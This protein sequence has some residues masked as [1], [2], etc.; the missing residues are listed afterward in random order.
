MLLLVTDTARRAACAMLDT[1]CN[2]LRISRIDMTRSLL[3]D[4]PPLEGMSGRPLAIPSSTI[5]I[6]LAE[7]ITETQ[8][9]SAT[10]LIAPRMATTPSVVPIPYPLP[11]MAAGSYMNTQSPPATLGTTGL[12]DLDLLALSPL[13]MAAAMSSMVSLATTLT[14]VVTTMTTIWLNITPTA[15]LLARRITIPAT[16]TAG[17]VP[18]VY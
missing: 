1:G 9:H 11:A 7:V 12:A 5:T 16:D 2:I 6:P 4:T 8:S 13:T 18:M 10:M 15:A 17:R 14:V 3:V